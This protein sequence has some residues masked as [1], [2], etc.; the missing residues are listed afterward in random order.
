MKREFIS[1]RPTSG[2]QWT[3]VSKTVSKVLEI[4]PGLYKG[5]VRQRSVGTGS[6]AVKVSSII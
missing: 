1:V 6:K 4:L 5:S 2:R 3:K